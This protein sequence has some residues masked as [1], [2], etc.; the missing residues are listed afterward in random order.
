MNRTRWLLSSALVWFASTCIADS[1]IIRKP[2]TVK[3]ILLKVERGCIAGADRILLVGIPKGDFK[4]PQE[5]MTLYCM[6]R[7]GRLLWQQ[8]AGGFSDLL[9][10]DSAVC[11]AGFHD[12]SF[13]TR[14]Y[15]LSGGI[16]LDSALVPYTAKGTTTLKMLGARRAVV[17]TSQGE[18]LTQFL[19]LDMSSSQQKIQ[20]AG[21][22]NGYVD[23]AH[24][25]SFKGDTVVF[26]YMLFDPIEQAKGNKP[27]SFFSCGIRGNAFTRTD[28]IVGPEQTT[29]RQFWDVVVNGQ[30]VYFQ[31]A[32]RATQSK[33]LESDLMC[34]PLLGSI[35]TQTKNL[36]V[37]NGKRKFLDIRGHEALFADGQNIEIVSIALAK[38]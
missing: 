16:E 5:S 36:M 27:S 7:D 9:V 34:V 2:F 22:V 19:L 38:K 14:S 12:G 28:R 31:S 15:A 37:V 3:E 24:G 21:R 33:M 4:N 13:Y 17:A 26:G 8:K 1:A 18:N 32:Y 11:V 23:F 10:I 25:V 6:D 20:A 35:S 29:S 30:S